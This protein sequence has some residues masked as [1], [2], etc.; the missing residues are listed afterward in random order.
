VLVL[1]IAAILRAF[2]KRKGGSLYPGKDRLFLYAFIFTHVQLLLG[3]VLYFIS[4]LVSWEGGMKAVMGDSVR[5]FYAVEHLTGMLVAIAIITVGYLKAK[6]QAELNKGWKT[7]GVYYLI[8][9]L[10][11][12]VSI[13]W[14]FR[15]LGAGWF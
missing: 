8:G 9:L 1:L 13:P 7:I 6:R 3:L 15:N 12:L 2:S 4:P 14:P 11:I 5:R 10:L